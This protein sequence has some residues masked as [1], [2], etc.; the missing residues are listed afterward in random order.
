MAK[1]KHGGK[2]HSRRVRQQLERGKRHMEQISLGCYLVYRRPKSGAAGSWQTCFVHPETKKQT[3]ETIALADDFQKPDGKTVLSF[4]Q[5]HAAALAWFG[6][7]KKMNNIDATSGQMSNDPFTV[8]NGMDAYFKDAE[9]RGVKGVPQDRYR[10]NAWILPAFGSVQISE[11]TRDGIERWLDEMANS[12]R[13]VRTGAGR[14]PKI[15]PPPSTDEQKR[16]RKESANR[17]LSVFKAALNYCMD[18]KLADS[19]DR[20]WQLVKRFKGTTKA[21]IRFLSIEEQVR[22][23][24]ACPDDFGQLV[25]GALLTG[26]R[27]GEMTRVQCKDYDHLSG[28]VFVAESKSGKPRHVFLT[29]EGSE[30]FDELTANLDPEDYV[31]TNGT[32]GRGKPSLGRRRWRS[33]EQCLKIREACK[34]AGIEPATFHELRHT[35]ASMLVNRGCVLSVV[36]ELL[37]HSSIKMVEKH[38]GHLSR[39]TV[40]DELLR[41]MPRLGILKQAKGERMRCTQ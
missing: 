15:N 24:D 18:R 11:L 40:R 37:G 12:P 32:E 8:A 10:A 26:C 41:A 33:K 1:T 38:Y 13:K 35:Y 34:K 20:P 22:L 29:K 25:R 2:L 4:H 3:R 21:R 39:N 23:V 19:S 36:A 5:A 16:A 7:Q 28:S 17:V 14:E 31:F 30:L 9:R 6:E 27:Y